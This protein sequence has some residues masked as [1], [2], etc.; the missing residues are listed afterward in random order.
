MRLEITHDLAFGYDSWIH[1]SR[2]EL[3]IQ[4]RSTTS[5]LVHEFHL[6][7]DPRT[8]PPRGWEDWL[9][10]IIHSFGISAWHERI[11]IQARSIV[12]TVPAHFKAAELTDAI[13]SSKVD[14]ARDDFTVF[15]GPIVRSDQLKKTS[16]TFGLDDAS[17]MGEWISR[18][19]DGLQ[20]SFEY[21]SQVTT[22]ESN[23]D[24]FL[25]TRA[26]VCQDFAH[27]TIA[28]ARLQGIPVRYVNGYLHV[29]QENAQAQSHAWVEL[30][31]PGVGWVPFDPTHRVD[32]GE[33]HVIVAYGRNYDD[34]PPNRGIYAGRAKEK[35]E[36]G[37]STRE[38]GADPGR[39]WRKQ[40]LE[41]LEIPTYAANPAERA[42]SS[43]TF[44]GGRAP[45]REAEQQQQQ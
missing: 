4:P 12:E 29:T 21:R 42:S 30:W 31:T 45:S 8:A 13:A 22:W 34:C 41:V 20:E 15:G 32:P 19:G 16:R 2:M 37:V 43:A 44:P 38:I 7:V 14:L 35:L 6:A 27:L 1:E 39:S 25:K 24:D 10:N 36:A 11:E 5:Q 17:T 23:T 26:G 33:C 9:G 28:L 40:D 18:L 3:R